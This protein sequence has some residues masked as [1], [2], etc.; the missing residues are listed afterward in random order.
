MGGENFAW[1][2]VPDEKPPILEMSLDK[3]ASEVY[4]TYGYGSLLW[5][6]FF[7]DDVTLGQGLF[8]ADLTDLPPQ[9]LEKYRREQARTNQQSVNERDR[10][11]RMTE[12]EI[13]EETARN[14]N[15]EFA[16]HGIP[17]RLET[18]EEKMLESMRY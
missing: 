17:H 18:N 11:K 3:D 10:R 16:K 2:I 6:R 15:D 14:W 4:Q 7:N 5:S 8:E 9:L 13:M 1:F 12:E